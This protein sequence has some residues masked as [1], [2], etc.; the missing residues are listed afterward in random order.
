MGNYNNNKKNTLGRCVVGNFRAEQIMSH[1]GQ[2]LFSLKLGLVC[3]IFL[4]R[5]GQ[6]SD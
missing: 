6:M 5:D 4:F 1:H 2:P 3:D